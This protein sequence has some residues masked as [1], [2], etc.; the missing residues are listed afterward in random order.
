[1]SPLLA[2]MLTPK[3]LVEGDQVAILSPSG[4]VLPE[5]LE[6]GIKTLERWGLKPTVLPHAFARHPRGY[7]AGSDTQR[8]EALKAALTDPSYRAVIFSRGGYGMMRLLPQLDP[9]WLRDDPKPLVGFSDITALHLWAAACAGV[10]TLHGPVI[11][12]FALHASED[13]SQTLERLRGALFGLPYDATIKQLT[14]ITPGKARGR[15]LGGNLSLI[16][17]ML[18][19]PYCPDL[20]GALLF[21][22]D[23]GEPD[24]RLDRLLM[25][26][27][28]HLGTRKLAGLLLGDFTDCAGVYV[29]QPQLDEFLAE[30]AREFGV[31]AIQGLPVGHARQN[32]PLPFGVEAHLDATA[33]RLS[34]PITS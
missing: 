28:L 30:L 33:G 7:L 18:G 2:P 1:M 15:L 23:V 20:E 24:Y 14:C 3:P 16:A 34:W 27:R 5:H 31:P 11:K 22:E 19:S 29:E 10:T 6:L 25:S 13:A 21:L 32:V 26:V 8:L 12:S 9:R 17:S 4:P